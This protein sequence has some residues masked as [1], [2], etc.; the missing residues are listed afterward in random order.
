[1]Q[2]VQPSNIQTLICPKTAYCSL[3]ALIMSNQVQ[4][5]GW[6]GSKGLTGARKRLSGASSRRQ[7]EAAPCPERRRISEGCAPLS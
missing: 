2:K 1:M 7:Q 5:G 6:G 3:A 4:G